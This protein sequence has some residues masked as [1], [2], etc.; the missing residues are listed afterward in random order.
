MNWGGKES[1][2]S[3]EVEQNGEDSRIPDDDC[4]R[5]ECSERV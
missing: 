2:E 4:R 1:S 3:V 5:V